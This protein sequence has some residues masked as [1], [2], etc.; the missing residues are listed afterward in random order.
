MRSSEAGRSSDHADAAPVVEPTPVE[1]KEDTD[2]DEDDEDVDDV[3][4]D[5]DACDEVDVVESAS[6]L[7]MRDGTGAIS[8][9]TMP[10]P[11]PPSAV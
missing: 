11:P 9:T 4:D 5:V 3:D 1:D 2:E 6:R 7:R 10:P 8:G